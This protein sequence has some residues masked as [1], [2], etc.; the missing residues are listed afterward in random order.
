LLSTHIK[1]GVSYTKIERDDLFEE[2]EKTYLYYNSPERVEGYTPLLAYRIFEDY[3]ICMYHGHQE[4]TLLHDEFVFIPK[5]SVNTSL[6]K[7]IDDDIGFD[8]YSYEDEMK[9]GENVFT[10][11]KEVI[12]YF[13]EDDMNEHVEDD[14]IFVE[15]DGNSVTE[16]AHA[17]IIRTK[18]EYAL[19]T[20][21]ILASHYSKGKDKYNDK[22]INMYKNAG[23]TIENTLKAI[24]KDNLET[25]VQKYIVNHQEALFKAID[26]LFEFAE[27]H[28]IFQNDFHLNN[29]CI[30][31]ED[32]TIRIRMIDFET[33]RQTSNLQIQRDTMHQNFSE[34]FDSY[35][36]ARYKRKTIG[37][38][39]NVLEYM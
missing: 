22:C 36:R 2:F 15:K 11:F 13:Q 7:H 17:M 21:P 23:E 37:L 29:Y 10:L 14:V 19:H 6:S 20:S 30:A 38:R 24:Q 1:N 31:M 12:L 5:V 28:K 39:E 8:F 27:R 32:D 34:A 35:R 3:V 33:L 26:T 25:F 4:E 9:K 16:F 18:P